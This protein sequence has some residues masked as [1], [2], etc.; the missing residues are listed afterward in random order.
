MPLVL[1]NDR[2]CVFFWANEGEPLEP[3]HV[4]VAEGRHPPIPTQQRNN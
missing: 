4:H 3:I 2:Y 1:R